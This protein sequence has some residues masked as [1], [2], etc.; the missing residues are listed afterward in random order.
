MVALGEGW[1]FLMSEVPLYLRREMVI[2]LLE[3]APERI[4][5]GARHLLRLDLRVSV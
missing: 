3:A 5:I 1:R 4:K 2:L